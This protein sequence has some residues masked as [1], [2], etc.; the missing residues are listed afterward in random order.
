MPCTCAV[1][2]SLLPHFA[3]EGPGRTL[4]VDQDV[5]WNQS[6]GLHR[7]QRV[8]VTAVIRRSSD[9]GR[10][11]RYYVASG[12]AI[13]LF[14]RRDH[15]EFI[16]APGRLLYY[17]IDHGK[18]IYW[19]RDCSCSWLPSRKYGPDCSDAAALYVDTRGASVTHGDIAGIAVTRFTV[20]TWRETTE[21]AMAPDRRC[22]PLEF[23]HVEFNHLW[24]PI[25]WERS[26]VT[27]Y[28]PGEPPRHAFEP[29][30]GYRLE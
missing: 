28:I 6:W 14:P 11:V 7:F 21:I 26:I 1:V 29:P 15:Y 25:R 22:E 24:I 20:R 30:S 17:A 12:P 9:G 4:H 16:L 10:A 18:Q 8:G 5:W 13:Q 3:Q 27:K 2:L 19:K 23:K